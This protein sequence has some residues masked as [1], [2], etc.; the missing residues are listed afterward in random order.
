[1]RV[2]EARRAPGRFQVERGGHPLPEL[3]RFA[4]HHGWNP[5]SFEMRRD[6]QT[7]GAGNNDVGELSV[8]M[9]HGTLRPR[10]YDAIWALA[11]PDGTTHL[12]P[13]VRVLH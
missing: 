6:S 11:A 4:K 12:F 2:R 7:V 3:H 5:P 9:A 8:H 13:R 1:M 10:R